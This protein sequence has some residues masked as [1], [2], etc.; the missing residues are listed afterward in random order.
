MLNTLTYCIWK[1]LVT[2]SSLT[3]LYSIQPLRSTTGKGRFST[4]SLLGHDLSGTLP[5]LSTTEH[6]NVTIIDPV[7]KLEP[8]LALVFCAEGDDTATVGILHLDSGIGMAH[9]TLAQEFDTVQNVISFKLFNVRHVLAVTKT[10]F[11]VK[12]GIPA[13]PECILFS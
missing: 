7:D 13:F 4:I 6:S 2:D 8:I 3:F 12:V 1:I 9:D 11:D 10:V 5:A